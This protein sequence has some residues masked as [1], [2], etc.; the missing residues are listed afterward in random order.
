MKLFAAS[1]VLTA[2]ELASLEAA[3]DLSGAMALQAGR[4]SDMNAI[5]EGITGYT[6]G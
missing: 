1:G 5:A 6:P 3:A 4:L 2:D